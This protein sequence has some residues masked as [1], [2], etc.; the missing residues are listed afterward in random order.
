[1]DDLV[2]RLGDNVLYMRTV[3]IK[4]CTDKHYIH[5]MRIAVRHDATKDPEQ[6]EKLDTFYTSKDTVLADHHRKFYEHMVGS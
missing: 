3:D 2:D 6:N 5:G 1:M 4:V